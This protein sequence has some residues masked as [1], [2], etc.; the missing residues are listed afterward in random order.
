MDCFVDGGS[1]LK[2]REKTNDS[3]YFFKELVE[4][5]SDKENFRDELL[6]ILIAGRDTVA[7]LLGSGRLLRVLSQRPD[8][9]TKVRA[10]VAAI[11]KETAALRVAA[12][13]QVCQV[14]HQRRSEP[15][16]LHLLHCLVKL[17]IH[18]SMGT[19]E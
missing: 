8:T 10:E 7:S 15:P 12:Q 9:W 13:P 16:A 14:L 11:W 1:A 17:P 2:Q 5:T 19:V 4:S 6:N 18:E 3:T